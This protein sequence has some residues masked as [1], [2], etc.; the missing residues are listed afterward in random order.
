MAE[1]LVTGGAG[2]IGS[3]IVETLV[4]RGKRVR[5]LDSFAT[6]RLENIAP[7]LRK[8]ELV[9]G[10]LCDPAA[11]RKACGGVRFVLHL[12]AIPS[13]PRSV[14]DPVTT[15]NAN[16]DGTLNL[17]LAARDAKCGRFVF[18]SSSSVYGDT[19]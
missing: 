8:I 10:D 19:P 16:I 12:G 2:F 9:R 18:S 6:G 3:H 14:A 1:F 13:V 5:V 7:F 11:V 15:N 17:L 4:K